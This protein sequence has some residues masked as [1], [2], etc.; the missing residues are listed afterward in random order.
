MRTSAYVDIIIR[1]SCPHV[2]ANSHNRVNTF[3]IHAHAQHLL[4]RVY[5]H[6]PVHAMLMSCHVS[7]LFTRF[8]VL[9]L[10][11][12]PHFFVLIRFH[13]TGNLVYNKKHCFDKWQD[14]CT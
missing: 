2:H 5:D 11:S 14:A 12:L 1:S 8:D 10:M 4:M 13:I 7:R 3:I 6:A 9:V